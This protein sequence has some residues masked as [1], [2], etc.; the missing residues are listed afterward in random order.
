MRD[1]QKKVL[2]VST[3]RKTRG[4]ITAVL[5]AYES[6]QMWRD[7]HCH[8]IGTH[9]DR[10]NLTKLW[11]YVSGLAEFCFL[12]PFYDIV[13]IHYSLQTTAKRKS[14]IIKIAKFLGKKVVTHLHCGSQIDDIW[15]PNYELLIGKADKAIFLS[16]NL[17]A[18]VERHTGPSDNYTVVYN[19]CISNVV[20]NGEHRKKDILFAA[21]LY[22]GKGYKDFIEAFAQI[23]SLH[24]D[25]TITLAGN[26]E[27]DQGKTL[28]KE[29]GI[30][31]QVIFLGWV[32]G[33]AKN[34]A[35]KEAS[36]FCLPSYA[37]GFPMAVLDAFSYGIPVITTPVGGI[38]DVAIDGENMLLF[39]PGDVNAL[40][41]CMERLIMDEQLQKRLGK[42]SLEFAATTFNLQMVVGEVAKI[43]ESL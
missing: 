23:A 38:P 2:V 28:A 18:M 33:E 19:P 40:A 34:N 12:L 10:G 37:E 21:T 39:N 15:G 27:I 9:V 1:K 4:G 41:N 3:S 16:Q 6:T 36:V 43:Y 20:Y 17:Q 35:F 8:W 29:L 5:K 22:D 30:A 7:Y 32:N 26:G 14:R 11:Y 13:H 24:K 25:W 31:D 42:A